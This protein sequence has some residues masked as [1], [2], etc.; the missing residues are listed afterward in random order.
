MY[1]YNINLLLVYLCHAELIHYT[2]NLSPNQG[3]ASKGIV[4]RDILEI[5]YSKAGGVT[6]VIKVGVQHLYTYTPPCI[7][8]TTHKI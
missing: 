1:Y 5:R 3:P 7:I 4:A 8:V 2:G 6:E